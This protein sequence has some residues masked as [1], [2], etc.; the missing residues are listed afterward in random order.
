LAAANALGRAEVG[1]AV[2]PTPTRTLA[3]VPPLPYPYG[4]SVDIPICDRDGRLLA[5]AIIDDIDAEHAKHQWRLDTKGYARRSVRDRGVYLHR[6]ILGLVP[7]DGLISDHINGD[8]LDNRRANLRAATPAQNAQNRSSYRDSTSR[9][10]GVYWEPRTRK[11]QARAK[12]NGRTMSLG[13]FV[14]EDE[15]AAVAAFYRQSVFTHTNEL[16]EPIGE[17]QIRPPI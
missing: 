5:V 2:P 11:W 8:R 10:R 6:E 1:P 7:G 3:C 17:R 12:V 16:R 4:G 13:C 15:A 9:Y 14:D